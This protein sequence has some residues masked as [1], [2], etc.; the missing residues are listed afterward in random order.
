MHKPADLHSLVFNALEQQVAVIDGAGMIVDVNRAWVEFGRENGIPPARRWVGSNYLSALDHSAVAGESQAADASKGIIDVL[1][2]RRAN[3][4]IEY[5]CHSPNERRW[6]MMQAS[7]LADDASNLVVISHQNITQRKLAEER[8]QHLATHDPLTGLA[9]RRH[10][11]W[12]LMT[13]IRR[14]ARARTPVSLVALDVDY[15]KE[16]ND[17]HG[18][19][20]GDKCL[21][22]VASILQT[23][24]R[25]PTDMA[26]RLGGDEFVLLLVESDVAGSQKVVEGIVEA[27]R[28]LG[29]MIDDKGPVT[30][31][32]GVITVTPGP[33]MSVAAL[34]AAADRALYQAKAA[35]RNCARRLAPGAG[36]D[37]INVAS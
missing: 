34:T 23:A 16:Y 1:R 3:F 15:F 26:A 13:E 8:V 7:P 30:A 33:T 2:G 14:S 19:P 5:P 31:S 6:F 21:K 35:G 4:T 10:F 37:L 29:I 20:E 17:R 24:G 36:N 27:V 25:R 32:V 22:K 11:N 18:H 28:G 9:N 12:V